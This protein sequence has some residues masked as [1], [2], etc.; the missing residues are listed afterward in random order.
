[1]GCCVPIYVS[2]FTAKVV[3]T[4]TIVCPLGCVFVHSEGC[5]SNCNRVREGCMFKG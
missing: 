1:M 5:G 4:L 3:H 2:L